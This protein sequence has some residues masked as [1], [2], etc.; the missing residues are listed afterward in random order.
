[1]PERLPPPGPSFLKELDVRVGDHRFR[2]GMARPSEGPDGW[3]LSVMWVADAE[4]VITFRDVARAA[5]PPA[6]PPL[7]RLGPAIAGG[8]S[9]FILE[10]DGRLQ[11]RLGTVIP[12]DDPSRPWRVPLAIRAAFRFEPAR[13][14]AMTANELAQ[15]VLMAFRH[16]V[17]GLHR[18]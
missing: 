13:V 14:A 15:T 4:G 12:A 6:E 2:A 3:W 7:G 18:P 5:G 11:L 10:D 16:A 17:E 8:L 1:M 9:G